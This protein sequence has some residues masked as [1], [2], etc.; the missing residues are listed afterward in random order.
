MKFHDADVHG[1][2]GAIF[3]T[4]DVFPM[5]SWGRWPFE[6][7]VQLLAGGLVVNGVE[8]D[9][10]GLAGIESEHRVEVGV[11]PNGGSIVMNGDGFPG[12]FGQGLELRSQFTLT[13]MRVSMLALSPCSPEQSCRQLPPPLRR[14][15]GGDQQVVG[16]GLEESKSN[17]FGGVGV[18]KSNDPMTERAKVSDSLQ[19][20]GV[21][22]SRRTK[23]NENKTRREI[24]CAR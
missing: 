24:A 5:G 1:K 18:R 8:M 9:P 17:G 15:N 6:D 11:R 13:L 7:A 2:E 22:V 10:D 4:T 21:I 23:A 3:A 14:E 12:G 20:I 19:A 16:P